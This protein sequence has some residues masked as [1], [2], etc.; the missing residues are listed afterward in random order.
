MANTGDITH[1]LKATAD[2]QIFITRMVTVTTGDVSRT[3]PKASWDSTTGIMSNVALARITGESIAGQVETL[4]SN[5][6]KPGRAPSKKKLGNEYSEGALDIEFSPDSFD[7]LLAAA[8]RNEWTSWTSDE[9]SAIN[10]AGEGHVTC[11]TGQLITR[12]TNG[13]YN[14]SETFE[15]K[16]LFGTGGLIKEANGTY[17]VKELTCGSEDIKFDLLRKLGGVSGEDLF[18]RYENM[19]VNTFSLDVSINS[20]VTGS[21]GFMGANSPKR[22]DTANIKTAYGYNSSEP[23]SS[24]KF[25]DNTT[26]GN[27]YV[28]NL[29][30]V[31]AT[32]TD[33]YVGTT[34]NLW[35]NG[36]NITWGENVSIELNNN[37]QRKN[38]IFVKKAIAQTASTL[39][40]TGNY[41]SYVVKGKSE[42]VYN[43]A[44][45]NATN[46]I[47]FVLQD[48]EEDPNV[49]YLFQIFK[50]SFD[51]PSSSSGSDTY[52]D[53]LSWSSFDEKALR[54]L[55]IE[56]ASSSEQLDPVTNLQVDSASTTTSSLKVTWT[57]SVSSGVSKYFVNVYK[58]TDTSG[59]L[60]D[61]TQVN[62]S[63]EE[64]TAVGLDTDTDYFITVRAVGSTGGTSDAAAVSGKT[65]DS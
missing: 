6:L 12:W 30:K 20:I 37:L 35:I 10:P 65:A 49:M 34:G 29:D 18:Q 55:K 53:T 8:L 51:S 56:K 42:A 47:M 33:Q 26:D 3:V 13:E 1:S 64:Y 60:V 36:Q 59:E 43:A 19:N 58:G 23:A 45:E 39:D 31:K 7:D 14:S 41:Q 27:T 11:T 17:T 21:F 52:E 25:G 61:Y 57:D 22:L 46:E 4:E 48:K 63:T 44:V 38:A 50:S 54:I 28:S 24:V 15:A 62:T 5:E 40:I 2:G 16:A 32:S 9:A